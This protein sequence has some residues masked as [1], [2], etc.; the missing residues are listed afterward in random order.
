MWL[1]LFVIIVF[2]IAVVLMWKKNPYHP[3]LV[4]VGI[5][6]LVIGLWCLD[7]IFS[8][9]GYIKISKEAWFNFL[10][11]HFAFALGSI[12]ATLMLL[13]SRNKINISVLNPTPTPHN[14]NYSKKVVYISYLF[15]L[16]S[17]IGYLS[18]ISLV[19]KS[20]NL[21][22]GIIGVFRQWNYEVA[23]GNL[24]Q[25]GGLMG[26][27]Y[28]L[29]Q[30]A[31]PFNVY[32]ISFI[33]K[34]RKKIIILLS[35]AEFFFLLSPR[36]ALLFQTAIL[37]L[38]ILLIT[39]KIRITIKTI[40]LS[41]FLLFLFSYSQFMLNK[42]M[43]NGLLGGLKDIYVYITGNIPSFE[44]LMNIKREDNG[45]MSFA[46]FYNIFN[47]IG[48]NFNNVDMSIAFVNI[49]IPFNTVPYNYYFLMDFGIWGSFLVIFLVAYVI[50]YLFYKTRYS[51]DSLN[52]QKFSILYIY[53]YLLMGVIFSFRENVWITYNSLFL[54]TLSLFL[55][56]VFK[57]NDKKKESK[58]GE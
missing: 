58:V 46:N 53:C 12:T 25:F 49:P 38:L 13:H 34:N 56:V 40:S 47:S 30:I 27:L 5:W 18:Y 28:T 23:Y 54:I 7:D 14:P 15:F 50:T 41:M 8:I 57:K 21:G 22:S 55:A 20:V 10:V 36:R 29:P 4:Y 35:I 32:I 26:R 11:I 51:K 3:L 52:I 17:G 44:I 19:L 1:V 6:L 33:P 45:N 31:I 37:V 24:G 9:I 48:Y 39:K 42:S 43:G 2:L 16:L